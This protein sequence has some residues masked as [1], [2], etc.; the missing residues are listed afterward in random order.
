MSRFPLLGVARLPGCSQDCAPLHP[1]AQPHV[2]PSTHFMCSEI[3]FRHVCAYMHVCLWGVSVSFFLFC[4]HETISSQ[5][6]LLSTPKTG[7]AGPL[8][9][10][11]CSPSPYFLPSWLLGHQWTLPFVSPTL[12]DTGRDNGSWGPCDRHALGQQVSKFF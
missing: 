9:G 12:G 4:K 2:Q 7:A 3:T 5:N 6:I 11:W 10:S 8:Q 1:Y